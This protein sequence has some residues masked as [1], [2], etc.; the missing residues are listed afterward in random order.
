M[1]PMDLSSRVAA[2]RDNPQGLQQKYA[3][4]Q[5]LLDL[6]ALQKITKEKQDAARQMQL[7]AAQQGTPPTVAQQVEGEAVDLTKQE[8]VK[9]VGGVAQQ[10]AR[11]QGIAG[12]PAPNMSAQAM[13]TGGVVRGFSGGGYTVPDVTAQDI[14][15]AP[16]MTAEERRWS[17]A[18][19][20]EEKRL[21]AEDRARNKGP[22]KGTSQQDTLI[23]LQ[24]EYRAAI[25]RGDTQTAKA[26]QDEM[27]TVAS[28][29]RMSGVA[30]REPAVKGE[31]PYSEPVQIRNTP[32][33]AGIA[34]AAPQVPSTS[35]ESQKNYVP[36]KPQLTVDQLADNYLKEQLTADPTEARRMAQQQ[37]DS[38]Y[39][40]QA[41][42]MYANQMA[43]HGEGL[44][45]LKAAQAKRLQAGEGLDT[46]PEW[47]QRISAMA[48]APYDP[49]SAPAG[50]A[51]MAMINKGTGNFIAGQKKAAQD[52]AQMELDFTNDVQEYV[53]AGWPLEAAKL[54]VA[55][56]RYGEGEKG[57]TTART[58]KGDAAKS[59]LDLREARERASAYR[60]SNDPNK[61][62]QENIK[63]RLAALDKAIDDL[64]AGDGK[65]VNGKGY[66]RLEAERQALIRQ[67]E[68]MQ[69]GGAST[70][71]A[72]TTTPPKGTVTG[73]TKI[74]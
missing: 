31:P 29:G 41:N 54:E 61:I 15:R 69:Q 64:P 12:L 52:K 44:A 47:L 37:Y 46:R 71:T 53:K 36:R 34:S 55:K 58:G 57:E 32:A 39:G 20:G 11:T 23:I 30:Q 48:D 73:R 27:R 4:S 19:T 35:A 9:Q 49:K 6:M 26:L 1:N 72:G 62:L 50:L 60:T 8:L 33:P 43:Q 63:T 40:Q 28:T 65:T 5:D 2:Y 24:N 56:G 38:E 68:A 14:A 51:G 67:L 42:T 22:A 74:S 18:L 17:P 16:R 45:A 70:T 3:M 10:Q 21:T 59:I 25:K 13:A 7:Q 66:Q